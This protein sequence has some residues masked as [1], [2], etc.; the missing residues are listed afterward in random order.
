MINSQ[1]IPIPRGLIKSLLEGN[2]LVID[3][4]QRIYDATEPNERND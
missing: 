3:E 1:M 2:R 4:L